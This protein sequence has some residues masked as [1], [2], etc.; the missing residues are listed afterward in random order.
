MFS[1]S[2]LPRI[3]AFNF[4]IN[5]RPYQVSNKNTFYDPNMLGNHNYVFTANSVN[6][7]TALGMSWI[8]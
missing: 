3:N 4:A 7:D 5:N 6:A 8:H 2:T 1:K